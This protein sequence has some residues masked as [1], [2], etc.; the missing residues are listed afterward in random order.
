[1]IGIYKI[2]NPKGRVYV[3]QSINLQRRLK[4]YQ[5]LSKSLGQVKL[6]YS[7]KKY[8]INNHTFEVLEECLLQELNIRERYWQDFYS[9]LE[10]GLN[11]YLT[12]TDIL[13]KICSE[14]SRRKM[15]ISAKAIKRS[16]HSEETKAKIGAASKLRIGKIHSEESK[17]KM[18]LAKKGIPKGPHSEETKAKIRA[19]KKI[20]DERDRLLKE[21]NNC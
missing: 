13:P 16:P 7:F 4:E 19:A 9:T 11:C 20:R 8:G 2:T 3:G 12:S 14:E 10:R 5:V 6:H 21:E 15:S 1:M 18:S 17:H